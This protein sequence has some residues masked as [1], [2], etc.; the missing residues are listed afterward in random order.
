MKT[1]EAAVGRE[2][3]TRNQDTESRRD[4]ES[5]VQDPGLLEVGDTG[6]GWAEQGCVWDLEFSFYPEGMG[7]TTEDFVKNWEL[8]LTATWSK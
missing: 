1:R 8:N 7:G 6:G 3:S 2:K 5:G 4:E